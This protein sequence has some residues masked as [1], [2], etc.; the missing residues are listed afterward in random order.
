EGW[1]IPAPPAEF[2]DLFADF[3][4]PVRNLISAIPSDTLYKW[5]LRDRDPLRTW[6]RGCVT[7]LGDA[8]HPFLPFLGQGA[9]VAIED[10]VVLGRTVAQTADL[11]Q[12]FERYEATRKPRAN[13]LQLASRDQGT[14][15]QGVAGG[16]LGPG[17]TAAA[18]GLFTYNP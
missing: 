11:V 1:S 12:G 4:E 2:L 16:G 10:G 5:G 13:G 14:H 6:T 9:C 8:A 18:R 17:N 15:H 7:M 3:R